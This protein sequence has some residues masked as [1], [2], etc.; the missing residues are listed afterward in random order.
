[1]T[2]IVSQEIH[3]KSRPIG[4]PTAENFALA[5]VSLPGPDSGQVL[6]RNIYLSVD[7]YMRG[8]MVDRKSYTPPFRLDEALSG[9][10]VGQ[11]VQSNG[12]PFQVGDYVLGMQGWREY[13]LS[14]GKGL[15]CIDPAL[16]PIQAF[17][18]V[19]GMPGMT[20]YV[21]LLDIGQP[22]AGETVYVS[23][24][25]GAVGAIVGQIA[26]CKGC[27]VV[28]STGADDK[29]AWLL[30]KAK[31]DAAFNYKK[32]D[33]LR[34]ELANHC[35]NGVDVYFDNVGGDHLEA[36][37]DRMNNFGRIVACGMIA[38][39]NATEASPAPRNLGSMGGKRLRMQGFIV[40]DHFN[41][42][43]QFLADM[44]EWI[45]KGRI[46]WQETIYQGIENT[47][48]ALISLFTGQNFGKMLV[49]VGPDPAV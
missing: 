31:F 5:T 14:D 41:R 10:C 38:Q 39:Y 28:G 4:L 16:T 17:L 30:N 1:M 47:P 45:A 49:K 27:R 18:G 42:R 25:A 35:P 20:A 33:N 11:V 24:A 36:A 13:Y 6:V 21:G 8:R 48:K 7:P 32:V 2:A 23:A 46:I 40:S 22:K 9:G 19:V 15:T 3:L 34:T 29:V 44:R 37:I 12:G 43:P 26:K